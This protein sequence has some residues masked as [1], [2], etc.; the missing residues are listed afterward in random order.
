VASLCYVAAWEVI[1]SKM[2]PDFI[3]KYQAHVFEKARADGETEAALAQKKAEYAKYA[4]MYRNPAIRAAITFLEPLP[5]ALIV[6]LIS[7]GVLSRRRGPVASGAG[8]AVR[9]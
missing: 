6:T 4:E 8:A 3:E 7:A 5:V 2:V 9:A 1:Y